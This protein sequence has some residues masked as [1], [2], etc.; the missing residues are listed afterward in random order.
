MMERRLKTARAMCAGASLILAGLWGLW[1]GWLAPAE[2]NPLVVA[3]LGA[4]PLVLFV[5]GI[6]GG[7][8]LATA[9]AGFFALL[10]MAH[11][12]MEMVANP[13]VRNLAIVF[14]LGSLMLF[15]TA[16]YALRLQQRG[17]RTS[18]GG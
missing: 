11:G 5:P 3:L 13:E 8:T 15:F 14:T 1:Y 6:L 4:A 2:E 17:S 16:S 7:R 18:E 9:A 10:Y 12:I